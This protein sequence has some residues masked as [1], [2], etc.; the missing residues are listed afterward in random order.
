MSVIWSGVTEGGA[1]VPVQVT[2]AGKV[3]ADV[4]SPEPDDPLW[5]QSGD[6]LTPAKDPAN[7]LVGGSISLSGSSSG[8]SIL[9]APANAGNQ[10]FTF[11]ETGGELMVAGSSPPPAGKP[12]AYASGDNGTLYVSH[13]V[14][15][16]NFNAS[17]YGVTAIFS[18]SASTQ[19]YVALLD[20][21]NMWNRSYA[22]QPI[23][24]TELDYFTFALFDYNSGTYNLPGKWNFVIWGGDDVSKSAFVP[25][26][27]E[28]VIKG[29]QEKLESGGD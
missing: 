19:G 1:I 13:N 28:D 7:L 12:W 22:F 10:E 21:P 25:T 17:N 15:T 2:D 6:V 4:N 23:R 14:R 5:T 29:H 24:Y 20:I 16:I 18:K 8:S 11:P 27:Y 3:V 26:D 9:K